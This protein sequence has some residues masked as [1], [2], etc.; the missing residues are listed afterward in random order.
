[1][2]EYK[3][4]SNMIQ[5]TA[6]LPYQDYDVDT[7]EVGSTAYQ[8]ANIALTAFYPEFIRMMN[9]SSVDALV[10]FNDKKPF[11]LLAGSTMGMPFDG[12]SKISVKSKVEGQSTKVEVSVWGRLDLDL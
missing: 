7:V 6:E 11:T 9:D 10:K 4:R 3:E 1:M 5:P 8:D 2:R 12:L